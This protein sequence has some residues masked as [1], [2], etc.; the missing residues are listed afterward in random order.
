MRTTASSVS[1]SYNRDAAISTLTGEAAEDA[2]DAREA[3][4]PQWQEVEGNQNHGTDDFPHGQGQPVR[5][6][7]DQGIGEEN[8]QRNAGRQQ[9]HGKE[10]TGGNAS[11]SPVGDVGKVGEGDETG[12]EV[13]ALGEEL[14]RVGCHRGAEEED[15][16][17]AD[18]TGVF[19]AQRQTEQADSDQDAGV[20]VSR[21]YRK[22]LW[23]R[24]GRDRLYALDGVE[25]GLWQRGLTLDRQDELAVLLNL[26]D[27]D[28]LVFSVWH[29]G[30][31]LLLPPHL[32]RLGH[33]RDVGIGDRAVRA[34][35]AVAPHQRRRGEV[36]CDGEDGGT[37][38]AAE[39]AITEGAAGR[40]CF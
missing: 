35:R 23:S 10:N 13:H 29:A 3:Q 28:R 19:D 40:V 32:A 1:T 17:S 30:S 21:S 25:Y 4:Q 7:E 27:E 16:H 8:D 20:R 24:S 12:V 18:P 38:A 31:L 15:D 22:D 39:A 9:L 6:E 2:D 37:T 36:W 5:E 26:L 14:G 33:G 11:V 34:V